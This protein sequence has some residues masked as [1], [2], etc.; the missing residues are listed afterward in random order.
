ML[1]SMCQHGTRR[2]NT[3]LWCGDC[4]HMHKC[5]DNGHLYKSASRS[6]D[7]LADTDI[8][9]EQWRIFGDCCDRGGVSAYDAPTFRT[10]W[11]EQYAFITR[12]S[13]ILAM[14]RK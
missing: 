3:C 5:R 6:V 2:A 7:D 14:R 13:D 9:A 10:V 4:R 11:P 12:L 8:I 1:C